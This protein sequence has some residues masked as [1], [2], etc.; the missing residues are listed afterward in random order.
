MQKYTAHY[1]GPFIHGTTLANCVH[2]MLAPFG[3][4]HTYDA[5]MNSE[6]ANDELLQ[7]IDMRHIQLLALYVSYQCSFI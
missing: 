2:G 5:I 7:P 1:D 3:T 4:F 6:P